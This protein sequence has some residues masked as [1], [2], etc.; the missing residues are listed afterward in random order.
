MI[1]L[2][3]V[4]AAALFCF[5]VPARIC[6]DLDYD[7]SGIVA[8]LD[9]LDRQVAGLLN[10]TIGQTPVNNGVASAGYWTDSLQNSAP[11]LEQRIKSIESDLKKQADDAA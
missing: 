11:S 2:A 3:N 7:L 6:Q 8:Q 4:I 10:Y 9:S 5:V 1:Q